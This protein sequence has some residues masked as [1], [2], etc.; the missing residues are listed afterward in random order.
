MAGRFIIAHDVGTS[1]NKAVLVD[2]DTSI[3]GYT[4]HQYGVHHPQPGYAEQSPKDWWEA[5]VQTTRELLE[6]TGVKPSDIL[7]IVFSTQMAGTLP[8]DRDGQPLMPCMTWLDTRAHVQAEKIWKGL[9]KISGYNVFTLYMF[10]NITG[11]APGHTGKDPICKILWLKEEKPDIYRDTYKLLGCK[12]YLIYKCTGKY[13]TSMDEANVTW[14]MDTRRGRLCWSEKI[15]K[16]YG[17]DRDKLPDIRRSTDIAG[18]LTG[19]AAGELGLEPGL[20]VVVGAGDM[21][22]AAVGSGAVLEGQMH[23]YVGTSSWVACHIKERKKDVIHYIG[24]IC[25]ANPDMYL[26]VAEQ[27]TA[28]ACLDWVKD[29]LLAMEG[30]SY[31]LLSKMAAEAEPGSKGLLF[32]PWLFGERAPLDDA[33]VRGGFYNLSL[34]HSRGH[35]ARAVL[36]GVALNMK[37]ALYY[38][39]KLTG[40]VET[41]HMIGGGAASD[42]WCQ[43]FADVLGKEVLRI[44]DPKEAGARGAAIIAAVA[45]GKI[46]GFKEAASLVRVEK[47]YKPSPGNFK[48]YERLFREFKNIYKNNK[49]MY[50]RLNAG[51]SVS[52]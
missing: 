6:K 10:L 8:V 42:T 20:P 27:E 2:L 49:K 18:K 22:S 39:E 25:S 29:E 17:I 11:G 26:C 33:T 40:R 1:G 19:E 36:E 28:G 4:S 12:D 9:I 41:I 24:S 13:I 21:A 16:K 46:P 14:L 32:T 52:P 15:L 23:G 34:E 47:T 44:S 45:L 37:W 31:D 3:K 43:I 30:E 38:L 7:A 35:V 5:V 48:L 51:R 50:H